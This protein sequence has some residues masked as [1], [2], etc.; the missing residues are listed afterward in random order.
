MIF[1]SET[2]AV[3]YGLCSAASWGVADFSGGFATRRN[4]VFAVVI[5]SQI[6]AGVLLLMVTLALT[7]DLP[8]YPQMIWGGVAGVAG[9]VGIMALYIGLARGHMG[10]VS[11]IAAV[12]AAVI[13]ILFA[14]FNEGLPP[15]TKLIGFGF[16]F[17]AVWFLTRSE[18]QTIM[19]RD[20]WLFPLLA[21]IG[22]GVFF[23]CIDHVSQ[24]AILWPLV[25]VRV[26]S[27]LTV[28]CFVLTRRE[29]EWPGFKQMPMIAFIGIGDTAGNVFFALATRLGRL[30]IS[31]VVASLYPAV[32]VLLAWF[33]LK[34]RLMPRQWIGVGA[35]LCAL[36][37][38]S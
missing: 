16:A 5:L 32:T 35:A 21:G 10:I 9:S 14:F 19:Q 13:P 33:I 36:V 27:I 23:I 7:E 2:M 28:L 17:V 12:V 38:I 22:F 4:N 1:G 6:I 8:P 20:E 37:L 3:T 25:A 24:S 30:D 15:A 18:G 26:T 29:I 11:S 34:E 31:A